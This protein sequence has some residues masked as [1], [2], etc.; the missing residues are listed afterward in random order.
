MFMIICEYVQITSQ[1]IILGEYMKGQ[2]KA[3]KDWFFT[4]ELIV[5]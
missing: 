5:I 1:W 2:L 4:L 3:M